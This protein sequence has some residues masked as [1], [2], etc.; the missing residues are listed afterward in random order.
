MKS[1]KLSMIIVFSALSALTTL[2]AGCAT[3]YSPVGDYG[4]F[5]H[6][7][8][9][10]S[11][12]DANTAIVG[13][14]GNYATPQ[15]DVETYLLYR[16]AQVT[17]DYGYTNFAVI[18]TSSSASNINL[19]QR[20]D[21]EEQTTDRPTLHRTYYDRI[22]SSPNLISKTN[23]QQFYVA[24]RPFD[25]SVSHSAKSV[26]KMFEGPVPVGLPN[27]FSAYDV[28]AHLGPALGPSVF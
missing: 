12:I 11:L 19:H 28:I 8:Y 10:T 4:G 1:I 25:R 3:P 15:K 26:I 9:T 27:S 20:Y 22:E 18:S 14:I 2:I 23:T 16:C 6:G 13:F 24:Q 5:E 21:D 7:G 17:L